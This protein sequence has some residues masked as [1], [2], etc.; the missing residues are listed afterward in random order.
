M[1]R[2][3]CKATAQ[4]PAEIVVDGLSLTIESDPSLGYL[5]QV[6]EAEG[7][8]RQLATGAASTVKALVDAMRQIAG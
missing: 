6:A 5:Y 4:G 3:A 1:L 7:S 2:E 8:Q